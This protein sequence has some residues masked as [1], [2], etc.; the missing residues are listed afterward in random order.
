[1]V[2]FYPNAKGAI[3]ALALSAT[4]LTQAGNIP[5]YQ[6]SRSD[7]TYAEFSDGIPIPCLWN[8]GTVAIFPDG[9]ETPNEYV[10]QGFPIGFDYRFGGR[11]VDQFAVSSVGELFLGK[12]S[13]HFLGDAFSI[14]MTPIMKGI[15]KADI[16]YKTTGEVGNRIFTLQFKDAVLRETTTIKGK[17]S[18]QIRLYEADG[19]AEIAFTEL[20]TTYDGNG[21]DTGLHGWDKAD[22]L[23]LTAKG[24]NPKLDVTVSPKL[25]S[26]MLEADSYINWDE[27]DYDNYYK[28]TY[29]FSP[30]SDTAAPANAPTVSAV[31]NGPVMKITATR[32][33]GADA[34]VV[35]VSES[36]FTAADMPVDGE[37]FVAGT[38]IGN[39]TALYYGNQENISIDYSGLQSGKT[40]YVRALSVNGYPAYNRTNTADVTLA[41]TQAAPT[42]LTATPLSE[43]SISVGIN[44]ADNVIVA[45]TSEKLSGYQ[46]GYAGTF[47]TP[48]ATAKVGDEIAGGGKVVYVG[49]PE[50]FSIDC[51]PNQM[52][53]LR[54][55]T[56]KNGVL[57]ATSID[58]AGVP[59]P[60]F[61]YEPGIENYP[62]G[63]VLKGWSATDNQFIPMPRAYQGDM[64]IVA[65]T[66]IDDSGKQVEAYLSTPALPLN[67]AVKL[68]F[69]F[70]METVRDA[71]SSEEGG[72]AIPQGNDPGKFGDTGY[73]SIYGGNTLC[74]TINTYGGTMV[75][76]GSGT[77]EDGSS[78][79]ESVEVDI[80]EVG[81]DG[82][83]TFRFAVPSFSILYI[84]N[85]KIER[86]GEAPTAPAEAPTA[87][88]VEEDR[89]GFV[90][91]NCEK[92]S[93]AE[94]TLVLFSEK[95]FA[96]T[97]LPED[98]KVYTVGSKL[99]NATV[100]YYG[101][102]EKVEC[103]TNFNI[104]GVN[105]IFTDFDADY[106]V[107]AIS[108]SG[109]PLYNRDTMTDETYHTLADMGLPQ[110][111]TASFGDR[112]IV[113]TADRYHTAEGTILILTD[114]EAFKGSLEDGKKYAVGETVGNGR[115]IYRGIDSRI[116]TETSDF[117]PGSN[118]VITGYSYNARGWYGD[119]SRSIDIK[120]SGID[121][122]SVDG[123]DFS[124]TEIYTV[125]GVRLNVGSVDELPA[126]IYIVNGK[127]LLITSSR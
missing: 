46:K 47:G 124:N 112:G 106:Y 11:L 50:A 100:L 16:S 109:N 61:P 116:E 117:T 19:K 1:M 81:N 90:Y 32:A 31:Q 28:F 115:V 43:N 96:A 72:T 36:P 8:E 29:I 10:A 39:A 122:V 49:S 91:V 105:P 45:A 74:K 120:T 64:A 44:A 107:R 22:G 27:D 79:Y 54:A 99:G 110:N 6:F 12:G 25:V 70:A 30:V 83:I 53:Y 95:P 68:T 38:Q 52:M 121:A 125:T 33:Q 103:N 123:I 41:T 23:Q 73:L 127:K 108:A 26:N 78:T 59:S 18:L 80:S 84:K 94:Y 2:K 85:I 67:T 3:A 87:L 65:K 69:D 42:S 113:V 82:R 104:A 97:E 56:V 86:T 102:D 35:L 48:T 20:E 24:I 118:C 17:Y 7:G 71:A 111:L 5:Q 21:F 114:G 51:E 77:N 40:Y 55:W 63:E 4:L 126:G 119:G 57:S 34:T 92:G 66:G 76:A 101:N 75:S 14:G 9:C 88:T 62:T 13:V 89:S 93:D 98:G 37:T 15:S 58:A 60:S